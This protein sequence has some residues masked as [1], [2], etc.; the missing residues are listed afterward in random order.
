MGLSLNDMFAAVK[1]P[2]GWI[3]RDKFEHFWGFSP[4]HK[5]AGMCMSVCM[6]M[7]IC[8]DSGTTTGSHAR[9]IRVLVFVC[10]CV[11]LCVCLYALTLS[12]TLHR[13]TMQV[14]ELQ[15]VGELVCVCLRV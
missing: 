2:D 5:G 6:S 3:D 7:S 15:C 10:L 1:M 14:I 13:L 8:L 9:Y 11:C 4:V 12:G